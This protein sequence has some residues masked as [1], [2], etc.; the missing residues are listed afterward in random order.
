MKFILNS[1]LSS[2]NHCCCLPATLSLNISAS[3]PYQ[4]IIES[5]RQLHIKCLWLHSLENLVILSILHEATNESWLR[6]SLWFLWVINCIMLR[7]IGFPCET[8]V[9][10]I[11]LMWRLMVGLENLS[12][13]VAFPTF[14]LSFYFFFLFFSF[15]FLFPCHPVWSHVRCICNS[16]CSKWLYGSL[17]KSET[18]IL[19]KMY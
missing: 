6:K 11:K 18:N 5:L 14:L 9:P 7:L 19:A 17:S 10:G 1:F 15:L 12:R 2:I 8:W 16:I 4:S 13:Y 3:Q